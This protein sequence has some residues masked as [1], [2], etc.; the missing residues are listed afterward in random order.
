ML[1]NIIPI[2]NCYFNV[3][4]RY[5]YVTERNFYAPESKINFTLSEEYNLF[6][7]IWSFNLQILGSSP[8]ALDYVVD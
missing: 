8:S 6:G 4:K 1:C 7:K 2:L 5:Y 3:I